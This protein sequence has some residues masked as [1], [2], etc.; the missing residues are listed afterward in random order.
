MNE[1][2]QRHAARAQAAVASA[3]ASI[4]AAVEEVQFEAP[5]ATSA[6]LSSTLVVKRA[7]KGALELVKSGTFLL[8]QTVTSGI[9][10]TIINIR[11]WPG[12]L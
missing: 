11:K 1:G 5:A 2:E 10:P 8:L 9:H 4:A 7:S 3:A 12:R 6:A